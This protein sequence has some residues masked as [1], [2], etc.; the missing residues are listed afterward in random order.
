MSNIQRLRKQMDD[1][2]ESIS[3]DE[4][5]KALEEC[6]AI[7]TPVGTNYVNGPAE[8]ETIEVMADFVTVADDEPCLMAYY[9]CDCPH[10]SWPSNI[11]AA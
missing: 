2:F 6:G 4:F 5:R 8:V 7:W 11:E 1:Y 10:N 9:G 3:P